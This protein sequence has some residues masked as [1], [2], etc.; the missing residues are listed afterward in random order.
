MTIWHRNRNWP[1]LRGDDYVSPSA[2]ARRMI[3]RACEAVETL[4]DEATR[5]VVGYLQ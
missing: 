1:W 3:A 2:T 5:L 4:V